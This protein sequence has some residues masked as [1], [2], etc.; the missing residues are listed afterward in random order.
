MNQE[1]LMKLVVGPHISEKSTMVGDKYRQIVFKVVPTAAKPEIKQAIETIFKV[2]IASICVANMRGKAKRFKNT[3]GKRK[4]W[5]KAY[6]T[7]KEGYDIN[8]A[9]GE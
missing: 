7:L 4:N 6:V 9:G 3:M 2:K 8:F 1:R 5:K